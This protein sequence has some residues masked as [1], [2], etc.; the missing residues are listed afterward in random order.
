MSA[1]GLATASGDGQATTDRP[2]QHVGPD[3]LVLFT[4]FFRS[5]LVPPAL[6]PCSPS[7]EG[8]ARARDA[9]DALVRE[10][11]AVLPRGL[12]ALREWLDAGAGERWLVFW[13][14]CFRN[15]RTF[16]EHGARAYPYSLNIRIAFSS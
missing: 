15:I 4:R 3:E 11:A 5:L 13:A 14:P 8:F 7:Y 16:L 1:P 6:S 10:R 12:D 2:F 9:L